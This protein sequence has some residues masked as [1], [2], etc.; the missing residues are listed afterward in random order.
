VGVADLLG[1]YLAF[2]RVRGIGPVRV[3]NLRAHFGT[4]DKAWLANE[5]DLVRAGLSARLAGEVARVRRET[6]PE[7]EL[8]RTLR[9]GVQAVCL[10]DPRYPTLLSKIDDP[11]P[12]LFV[13]G[14][15]GPVDA[16]A[17]AVVG[18]RNPTRYGRDV[19]EA[20]GRALAQAGVLVV[21]GLA[22]GVDAHT[23]DATLRAGGRTLGVLGCG[24]DRVYPPE[25]AALADRIA[26]NGAV[27]SDYPVGAPPEASNFP[28]R[29][30]I[31]SGI[32]S[33]TI[34]VEADERSGA[35]ITATF[36]AEQGR[37]VLAV[38]GNIFNPSS[39]GP[40]RLIAAGATP[41]VDVDALPQLLNLPGGRHRVASDRPVPE[42]ETERRVLDQ[43]S[44]EP[45]PIDE[46]VRNLGLSADRV[47]A[48]LILMTV[49]GWVRQTAGAS[50]ALVVE[51]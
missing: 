8:E 5:F 22:R 36:A 28:A 24:V 31:I 18:T 7:I 51:G 12:V 30:R 21:S 45:V 25:H 10:D 17:V 41:V 13:R 34:V 9:A 39:R 4:L 27:I 40:N 42:D 47:S 32:A 16:P 15:V 35:L 49:R 26:G 3:R 19:A 29:N 44:H 14:A 11:P 46:I 23:H 38:P 43:L 50:Y 37:D 1:Y 6:S 48:A 2:A 20:I 33:A